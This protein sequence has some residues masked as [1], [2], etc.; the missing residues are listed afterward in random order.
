MVGILNRFKKY[1]I[2]T[3]KQMENQDNSPVAK[4]ENL[5]T[6]HF[7]QFAANPAMAAVIFSEEIFQNEKQLADHV[8]TIMQGTLDHVAGIIDEGQKRGQMR[9]DVPPDQLTMLVIGALRLLV[10]RWRLSR[11]AFDLQEQGAQLCKTVEQIL[12]K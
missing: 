11:H 7:E 6:Q 9:D 4:L 12:R 8:F 10:T 1:N 2:S 3:Q 5:F